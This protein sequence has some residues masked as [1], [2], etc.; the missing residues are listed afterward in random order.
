MKARRKC[1]YLALIEILYECAF[2]YCTDWINLYKPFWKIMCDYASLTLAWIYFSFL[3]CVRVHDVAKQSV[4]VTNCQIASANQLVDLTAVSNWAPNIHDSSD[5]H[6][7]RNDL[8]PSLF[9]SLLQRK[10]CH[11]TLR[12]YSTIFFINTYWTSTH[13]LYSDILCEILTGSI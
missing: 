10:V 12:W 7:T 5:L 11:E 4:N 9:L 8:L 13:Q 2:H 6:L 3:L 1:S